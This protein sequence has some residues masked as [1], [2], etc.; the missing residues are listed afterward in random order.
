MSDTESGNPQIQ[1][2]SVFFIWVMVSRRIRFSFKKG[3][4]DVVYLATVREKF[5]PAFFAFQV[6]TPQVSILL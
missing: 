1:I 2:L 4:G 3:Q 5:V 6:K